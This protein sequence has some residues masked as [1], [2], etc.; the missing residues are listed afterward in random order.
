MDHPEKPSRPMAA[1][2]VWLFRHS[3]GPCR[4]PAGF[5]PAGDCP[6]TML[7]VLISLFADQL[8]PETQPGPRIVPHPSANID[9][10]YFSG[11][12]GNSGSGGHSLD[13][14]GGASFLERTGNN[15]LLH[16]WACNVHWIDECI[17]ACP[18]L[19]E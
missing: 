13:G 14:E 16:H 15:L 2:L 6:L 12:N 10:N 1:R 7:L 3:I 11:F 17:R 4:L 18:E 19:V 9:S 5:A 8:K